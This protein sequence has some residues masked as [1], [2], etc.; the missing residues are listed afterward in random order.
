M[1][2]RL[3]EL[4][5]ARLAL[6]PVTGSWAVDASVAAG[7]VVGSM[8]AGAAV[9]GICAAGAEVEAAAWGLAQ[10]VTIK[11]SNTVTIKKR[12]LL[13]TCSSFAAP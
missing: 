10:A 4:E 7:A 9:A 12:F 11:A 5:S 2:P 3:P 6:E 8:V 1:G 13:M